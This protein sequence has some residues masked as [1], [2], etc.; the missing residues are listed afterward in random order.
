MVGTQRRGSDEARE[1]SREIILITI[2]GIRCKSV[3]QA[4]CRETEPVEFSKRKK[5]KKM[6]SYK[7]SS[8]IITAL[9]FS[10]CDS[11]SSNRYISV[12]LSQPSNI[13][14]LPVRSSDEL[15][16]LIF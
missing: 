2:L 1:L 15:L 8:H 6:Q 13:L 12:Y 14:I 9:L 3:I 4:R 7:E 10:A 16:P 5:K 11:T